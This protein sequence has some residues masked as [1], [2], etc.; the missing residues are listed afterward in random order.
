M[1]SAVPGLQV[2][3]CSQAT[4]LG[5]PIGDSSSIDECIHDKTMKLELMGERL[6]LL[7]SHDSLLLLRHSLR[8]PKILYVLRTALCFISNHLRVFD[9]SILSDVLN[10]D[11]ASNNAWLQA[12]LPVRVGGIGVRQAT[13]LVPSAY[14]DSATGCL[15]Q[16]RQI[17]PPHFQGHSDPYVDDAVTARSQG[18]SQPPPSSPAAVRQRAWDSIKVEATY[19]LLLESATNAQDQARLMAVACPESGAWLNA[20]PISALGLRMDDEVIRIAAGLHLGF[21]LCRSHLCTCCN[22]NVDELGVHDLCCRFSKGRHSRHASLNDIIKRALDSAK[23]PCHQPA[24]LYRSDGKRPD[25]ESV[26]PW[27]GVRCWYGIQR[28]RTHWSHLTQ[29]LP[30][31]RLVLSQPVQNRERGLSIIIIPAP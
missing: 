13:Q 15:D 16:I 31:E 28:V 22:S 27:R 11:L 5:S 26:V 7:S 20:L 2:V 12:S 18:H 4:L 3:G 10:V 8:I 25:G 30:S 1:L 9:R 23:V 17:L 21:P 29:H 6:H 19:S 24:S 14:L